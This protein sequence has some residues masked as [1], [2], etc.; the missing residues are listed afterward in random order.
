VG[1]LFATQDSVLSSQFWQLAAVF[2]SLQARLYPSSAEILAALERGEIDIAYNVLG[3]YARRRAAAGAPIEVVAP[4]DYTLVMS[5]VVTISKK[6]SNPALAKAFLDYLLS[7]RGQ[8]VVDSASGLQAITTARLTDAAANL[9]EARSS[10][11]ADHPITLGPALL[12]FLDS[13]KRRRFLADWLAVMNVP[14][15]PALPK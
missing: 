14:R 5:R 3:S 11:S 7:E 4:E 9:G 1:Y 2:G 15:G 8:A 12:V 13:M 6:A 10:T